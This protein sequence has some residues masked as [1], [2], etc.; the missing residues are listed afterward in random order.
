VL[1]FVGPGGLAALLDEL[2]EHV[3]RINET[4]L[5][6]EYASLRELAA[7]HRPAARAVAGG[8]L[9]ADRPTS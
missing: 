1:S 8:V 2:V 6:G 9:L 4:V 5:A 7:G 3:R